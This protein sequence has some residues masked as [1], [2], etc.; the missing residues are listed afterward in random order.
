VTQAVARN[1]LEARGLCSADCEGKGNYFCSN[2]DDYR[3]TVKTE[4][5]RRLV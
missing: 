1:H 3:L 2:L 4:G 5:H